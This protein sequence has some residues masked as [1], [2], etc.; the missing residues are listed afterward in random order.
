MYVL[1]AIAAAK[2][3]RIETATPSKKM[4]PSFFGVFAF[5]MQFD[6]NGGAFPFL[7]TQNVFSVFARLC[8]CRS[9]TWLHNLARPW[10]TRGCVV[11]L[12][13][14]KGDRRNSWCG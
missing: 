7:R 2:K 5:S 3:E 11:S 9:R 13:A 12:R 8:E 4:S 10:L 1:K 14:G 6:M